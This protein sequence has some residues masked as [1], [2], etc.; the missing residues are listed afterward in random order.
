PPNLHFHEPNPMIDFDDLKLQVPTR[1][2][3]LE[4]NGRAVTVG[5]NSFGAGG[6]NAHTVLQELVT[7]GVASGEWSSASPLTTYDS[8]L[9][10]AYILS[11]SHRDALRALAIKHADFLDATGLRLEDAAFSAFTRRSHYAHMVAVVG[12]T[13]RAVAERLRSFA[14]GKIDAE[15]LTAKI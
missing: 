13:P 15:I 12:D 9:S 4:R 10:T 3:P 8:P 1:T 2:I 11:A 7:G 5:V 14:D 6:T